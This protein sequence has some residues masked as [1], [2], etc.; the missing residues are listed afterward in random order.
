MSRVFHH[1]VDE[2]GFEDKKLFYRFQVHEDMTLLNITK[3][4]NGPA[5]NAPM[6][7]LNSLKKQLGAV[8]SAHSD[9]EGLVDYAAVNTDPKFKVRSLLSSV[10][11]C[12]C[13]LQIFCASFL[14]P[15]S[16]APAYI[17]ERCVH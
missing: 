10:F 6:A 5:L 3:V 16:A 13:F 2:H 8:V 12:G 7:V 17:F 11:C 14:F 4:W 9:S 15:T 1:V